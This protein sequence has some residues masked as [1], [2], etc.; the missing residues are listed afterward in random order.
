MEAIPPL[1][2]LYSQVCIN[3]RKNYDT[4]PGPSLRIVEAETQGRNDG[5]FCLLACCPFLQSRST[6]IRDSV[7]HGGLA[8]LYQLTIKKMPYKHN[9][10]H[11]VSLRV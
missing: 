4:L 6:C 9:V 8:F 2:I 7:T 11:F 10:P 1:K 3:L 5:R